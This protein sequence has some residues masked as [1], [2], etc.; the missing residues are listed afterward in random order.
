MIKLSRREMLV[1]SAALA[2]SAT[3]AFSQEVD[4]RSLGLAEPA[5]KVNA[6]LNIPDLAGKV[7]Q[8]QDYQGK[9]VVVS[10]WA[11]WCPPCRKEMPTLARLGRELGTDDYAV[12]AVNVGDR[13]DKIQAF[14]DEIEHEGMSILLDNDKEMPAKWFLHGLPVTYI[15]DTNGKVALGAIGER[16]WDAPEMIAGIRSVGGTS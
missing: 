13:Q 4:F 1:G 14:L 5:F 11:T 15:V 10:F 12:L 3:P 7:H 2:A 6:E 16:V 9:T 8:L